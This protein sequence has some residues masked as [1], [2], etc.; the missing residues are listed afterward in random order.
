[1][2]G[3]E[4]NRTSLVCVNLFLVRLQLFECSVKRAAYVAL[5]LH[6][7]T[8]ATADYDSIED[9]FLLGSAVVVLHF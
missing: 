9:V 1:M 2:E 7:E 4:R 8:Y 6:E 3:K 5:P